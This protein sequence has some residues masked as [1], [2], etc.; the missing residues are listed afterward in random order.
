MTRSSRKPDEPALVTELFS[1]RL[2]EPFARLAV[3]LGISADAIT[4]A[5]GLCW[6]ISLPL[7]PLAGYPINYERVG[8]SGRIVLKGL[9]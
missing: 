7:A 8:G 4:V 5:G 3:R 2:A 9:R 1:R 6:M